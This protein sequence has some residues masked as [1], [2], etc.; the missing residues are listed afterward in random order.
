MQSLAGAQYLPGVGA[1][2]D[3]TALAAHRPPAPHSSTLALGNA[4]WGATG[5]G[6]FTMP[7]S[8]SL[9]LLLTS[10]NINDWRLVG[11]PAS[12]GYL[13]REGPVGARDTKT[14]AQLLAHG[15][16]ARFSGCLTLTLS[17]HLRSGGGGVVVVD[18]A[19]GGGGW[20]GEVWVGGEKQLAAVSALVP[21]L[22]REE[23]V[24][25]SH[26]VGSFS[27][28]S[29]H[30]HFQHAYHSLL[31]VGRA[32]LVVTSRI[33]VALPAVALGTPVIFVFL[34][35]A[36]DALPGGGG[37][38]TAGL[39]D[40]FH[41]AYYNPSKGTW[42]MEE[43]FDW[44]NPRA[45]PSPELRQRLV[46]GHWARVRQ[47]PMLADAARVFGVF[48]RPRLAWPGP[49][50][51]VLA[52]DVGLLALRS[53]ESVLFHHPGAEVTLRVRGEEEVVGQGKEGQG[54]MEGALEA[55]AEAGYKVRVARTARPD[56][57]RVAW[58]VRGGTVLVARVEGGQGELEQR[59]VSAA[60]LC[61]GRAGEVAN[62]TAVSFDLGL[63]QARRL[64]KDSPCRRILDDFTITWHLGA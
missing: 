11:S 22:T 14:L 17:P 64:A 35:G 32:R 7:P 28:V 61:G 53:V 36:E 2:V 57:E 23:V 49:V 31:Q 29:F 59:T 18:T 55:L 50:V 54:E 56:A 46:A 44:A 43:G 38:R 47:E 19:V 62:Y 12:L 40:L 20:Q 48:P 16:P 24:T 4:W 6:A 9:R 34:E 30:H 63:E 5:W 26:N 37:R 60:S 51:E 45:T 21:N 10:V 33:H 52:G 15:V 3:H 41:L 13:R 39:R 58:S 42:R 1:W 8:P 25:Y 27:D